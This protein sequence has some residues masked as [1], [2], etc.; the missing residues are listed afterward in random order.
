MV[1]KYIDSVYSDLDAIIPPHLFRTICFDSIS[2]SHAK[3]EVLVDID[4][5]PIFSAAI[6]YEMPW[7]HHVFGY[8][9]NE[10]QLDRLFDKNLRA[11]LHCSGIERK[12]TLSDWGGRFLLVFSCGQFEM[13]CFVSYHD[14]K[15]LIENPCLQAFRIRR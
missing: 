13:S 7:N 2:L 10:G 4:M 1:N 14:V 3:N 15:H 8:V 5:S 6:I 12:I 9:R 11:E